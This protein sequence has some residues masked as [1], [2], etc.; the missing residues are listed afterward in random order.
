MLAPTMHFFDSLSF[1][2]HLLHLFQLYLPLIDHQQSI[3]LHLAQRIAQGAAVHTKVVGQLLAVKGKRKPQ[4][5][6]LP[7]QH[8]EVRRD[9][10]A[11]RLGGGVQAALRQPQ[12]FTR[13]NA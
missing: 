1:P 12:I 8:R 5:A 2:S 11:D 9:P 7:R 10:P 4:A 3:L 13:C 6:V